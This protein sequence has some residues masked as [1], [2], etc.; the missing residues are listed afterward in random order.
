VN[1]ALVTEEI[2]QALEKAVAQF[3][4]QR[5]F[6]AAAGVSVKFCTDIRYRRSNFIH[7]ES[8]E[9]LRRFVEIPEQELFTR[10]QLHD[11][12]LHKFGG[13]SH[14]KLKFIDGHLHKLC[15]GMN[16]K[17]HHPAYR[18]I[19]DFYKD[20]RGKL[21]VRSE[22]KSCTSLTGGHELSVRFNSQYRAWL[23]EIVHRVGPVE[24]GRRIGISHTT[25]RQWRFH[26]PDV[27]RRKQARK[28]VKALKEIR[29]QGTVRHRDS[30]HH[31]SYLRG[32]KEKIPTGNRDYY[33][34]NSDAENE[35]K[36]RNAARAIT[37]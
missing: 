12:G 18:P 31:G 34:T 35:Q 32:R 15:H 24:A 9:M 23:M 4:T 19:G 29:T 11:M 13:G 14:A 2:Q 36:R 6:C 28:L 33:N 3:R 25:M 26:P 10:K 17:F 5:E 30:I 8:L 37:E 27:I 16:G 7:R 22:C 1:Y 21:G 20:D